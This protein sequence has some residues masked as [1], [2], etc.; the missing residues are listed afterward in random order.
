LAGA[1]TVTPAKAKVDALTVSRRRNLLILPKLQVVGRG[2]AGTYRFFSKEY[3][4]FYVGRRFDS[5][6]FGLE[7]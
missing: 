3:T 1:E 5:R 2:V 4:G 7:S 6:V